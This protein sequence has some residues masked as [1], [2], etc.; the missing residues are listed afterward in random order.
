MKKFTLL[1]TLSSAFLL[2]GCADDSYDVEMD[3][4]EPRIEVQQP[5]HP[6]PSL[7]TNN[8]AVPDATAR[9]GECFARLSTEAKYR[10]SQKQVVSVASATRLK[11]IPATYDWVEE[12]VVSVPATYNNKIIPATYRVVTEQQLVRG[13]VNRTINNAAKYK[14][15]TERQLVSPARTEWKAGVPA[16]NQETRVASNG[17]I[18]CLV[19]IPAEYRNVQKQV[20]SQAA[21]SRVAHT[22]AEYKTVTRRVVDIPARTSQVEV[23]AQY[24]MKRVRKMITP[25]R[26]ETVVIPATYR[27]AAEKV[28]V[29]PAVQGW[30]RILCKTNSNTDMVKSLQSALSARGYNVGTIDGVLGDATL[31][32]ANKF[33]AANGMPSGQISIRALEALGVRY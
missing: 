14:M 17:E 4:V 3:Y 13:E 29:S 15:V 20:I 24:M 5:H 2:S 11:V 6:V 8:G 9:P 33:Q 26:T 27:T 31:Q 1:A 28:L 25:E 16:G 30:G 19:Q 22:P 7:I 21:T 12:R 32:A 10:T 23:P 18:M